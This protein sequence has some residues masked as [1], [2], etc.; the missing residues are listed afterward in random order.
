MFFLYLQM[1]NRRKKEEKVEICT[2][3]EQNLIKFIKCFKIRKKLFTNQKKGGILTF[4]LRKR[5]DF[6]VPGFD[7]G[8]DIIMKK[9]L[10]AVLAAVVMTAS[11]VAC[12]SAAATETTV[13]TTTVAE[14]S[15]VAVESTV[16]E[17]TV[18]ATTE[19]ATTVEATTEAATT[20]EATEEAATETATETVAE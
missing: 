9:N 3:C 19:E 7:L 11:M 2:N 8:G 17:T 15:T 14:E 12:G 4:V 20:E 18:E 1:Q 16:E 5:H 13:E 10:V 6:K